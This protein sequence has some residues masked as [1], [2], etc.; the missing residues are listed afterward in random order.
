V[1]RAP[2]TG[3]ALH[4]GPHKH[5]PLPWPAPW[6]RAGARGLSPPSRALSTGALSPGQRGDAGWGVEAC[7]MRVL[8]NG[9]KHEEGGGPL[10]GAVGGLD[11]REAVD[12]I[13]GVEDARP[14]PRNADDHLAMVMFTRE[15][16]R[17][18]PGTR[19]SSLARRRG[20]GAVARGAALGGAAL[21]LRCCCPP[22]DAATRPSRAWGLPTY[23]RVPASARR[24]W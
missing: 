16:G 1:R 2:F 5:E 8:T 24:P 6:A 19:T 11:E 7:G 9:S 20:R 23:P 12:D 18:G 21:R 22:G 3:G 14:P 13:R 17:R 10:G 4:W 15:P